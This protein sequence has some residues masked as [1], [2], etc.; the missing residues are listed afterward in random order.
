[1]H[2]ATL[3]PVASSFVS[4]PINS[5]TTTGTADA[6]W[7]AIYGLGILLVMV[8]L[9]C[10]WLAWR[11]RS[12]V[13]VVEKLRSD[14]SMDVS[15]PGSF[16]FLPRFKMRTLL[17]MF[18]LVAVGLG[19]F[20]REFARAQRQGA[21]VEKLNSRGS[22]DI[23]GGTYYQLGMLGDSTL[24]GLIC[25][26]IHPH[27]GCRLTHLDIDGE[28]WSGVDTGLNREL[29]SYISRLRD[30]EELQI[31][32]LDLTEADLHSIASLPRLKT[33]SLAGCLVPSQ[34]GKILG[35]L[36][37]LKVLNLEDCHLGDEDIEGFEGFQ[38]LEC[39]LLGFNRLSDDAVK[40]L[41]SLQRLVEL[42]LSSNDISDAGVAELLKLGELSDL[43]LS[44]TE[45]TEEG[46][47]YLIE[48]PKL[49][50]V[51][52][53]GCGREIDL[54][55]ALSKNPR[56]QIDFRHQSNSAPDWNLW[57]NRPSAPI[58]FGSNS[59]AFGT[60]SGTGNPGHQGG[61]VF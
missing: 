16:A 7:I 58:N 13:R 22:F 27:F 29:C 52:L 59:G 10:C 3:L 26:W 57:D 41:V 50:Y 9:A 55:N 40:H 60:P 31:R 1:M 45:I 19:L 4:P 15:I 42:D 53:A 33:L 46:A 37:Q 61:G 49:N 32:S 23:L 38:Q 21:I 24:A 28:D 30:I 8:I 11:M 12:L 56:I 39:L 48:L 25:D 43:N 14:K 51:A 6:A 5:A 2:T 35:K 20:A 17:I 36:D 44:N 54:S 34:A 47:G 18:T